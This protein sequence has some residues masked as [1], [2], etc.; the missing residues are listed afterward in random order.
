MV[1][2][3]I[4]KDEAENICTIIKKDLIGFP[5]I[6]CGD[7]NADEDSPVYQIIKLQGYISTHA[8]IHQREPKVSHKNHLKEDVLADYILYR[9]PSSG[10]T[11][12]PLEVSLLP[13]NDCDSVWPNSFTISD[14]RPIAATIQLNTC[15][16]KKK[17]LL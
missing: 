9:N 7:L 14:H 2:N 13:E 10:T 15:T 11:I 16:N 4:Q 17:N 3:H 5:V 1:S 6:L 12:K 8:Q